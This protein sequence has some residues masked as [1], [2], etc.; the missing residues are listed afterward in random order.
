MGVHPHPRLGQRGASP[1]G[2][3]GKVTAPNPQKSA[4]LNSLFRLHI[5]MVSSGRV[6]GK[7]MPIVDGTVRRSRRLPPEPEHNEP[8]VSIANKSLACS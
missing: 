2:G 8:A 5:W 7:G 4:E 6:E 3:D 1:R